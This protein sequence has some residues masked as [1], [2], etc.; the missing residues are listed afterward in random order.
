MKSNTSDIGNTM[1]A[2]I[3]G[4]HHNGSANMVVTDAA[5]NPKTIQSFA[6]DLDGMNPAYK[7]PKEVVDRHREKLDN[8]DE[9]IRNLVVQCCATDPNNRP[10][11]EYLLTEV[12]R[13]VNEKQASD[14]A[15]K[16]YFFNET[17]AAI[18]RIVNEVMFD[19]ENDNEPK[20]PPVAGLPPPSYSGFGP[21]PGPPPP[22]PPPPGPGPGT[23]GFGSYIPE[24]FSAYEGGDFQ[25]PYY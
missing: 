13:N 19:A 22:P 24:G 7:A 9:D 12:E 23:G 1:L 11:I 20:L 3:G 8:L 2:L 17:D 25:M 21:G 4:S 18:G 5:G 15:A 16:K 14:Y 10:G 6:R